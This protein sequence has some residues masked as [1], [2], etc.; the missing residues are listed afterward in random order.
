MGS[1]GCSVSGSWSILG[2]GNEM[3]SHYSAAS[4]FAMI[5]EMFILQV[6]QFYGSVIQNWLSTPL[7]S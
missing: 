4:M 5:L 1:V 2:T 6:P 3:S 7:N